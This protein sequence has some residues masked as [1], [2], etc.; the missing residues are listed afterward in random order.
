MA[1]VHGREGEAMEAVYPPGGAAAVFTTSE[2]RD[3][4]SDGKAR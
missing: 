2:D 3:R 1:N 4:Y